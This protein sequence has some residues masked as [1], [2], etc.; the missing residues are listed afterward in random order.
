MPANQFPQDFADAVCA[1]LRERTSFCP[2]RKILVD[3]F[4]SMYF[5]SLKTEE[6]QPI[7]FHI[8][9]LD[10]DN[11]DPDPP[12]RM[13]KDRWST[14]KLAKPIPVTIPNLSKIAKASDP[15]TSSLAV[16]PNR[17]GRLSIWGLID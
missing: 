6:S 15:R 8:A 9:Y 14:V 4:E 10:P 2:Q 5:A 17:H 12:E 7:V 11:P 1:E 3:L 13:V 16:F